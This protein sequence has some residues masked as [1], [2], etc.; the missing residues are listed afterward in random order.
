MEIL[1]IKIPDNA[2]KFTVYSTAFREMEKIPKKYTCE[3]EDIS[4]PIVIEDLPEGTRSLLLFVEDP[5]APIGIF[6]HWIA[7]INKPV[8][9][10]PENIKKERVVKIENFEIIQGKNDFGRIGYNGPCPPK[11]HGKHRYYTIILAINKELYING[12]LFEDFINS[13]REED[14]IGYG[15][16][17]GIYER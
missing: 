4:F 15:Y 1:D 13:V 8:N 14:I 12:V 7:Y 3:G 17:V 10:I 9:S 11:G 6:R 5:D 2:K 16:T